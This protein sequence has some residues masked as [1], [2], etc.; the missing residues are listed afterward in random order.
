MKR[1]IGFALFIFL[2]VVSNQVAGQKRSIATELNGF[3]KKYPR[4]KVALFISQTK[5]TPGDT[6]W[7]HA[8][9]FEPS[10]TPFTQR[11]I[12]NLELVD[13][14]GRIVHRQNA[15][16]ADGSA[17]SYLS[18]PAA[19]QEGF[20]LIRAFTNLMRNF[21]EE[22]F[23]WQTIEVVRERSLQRLLPAS[24]IS[25]HPEGGHLTGG[26]MNHLV[27]L[28]H[29]LP[30]GSPV[31]IIGSV[32]GVLSTLYVVPSGI[33]SVMINPRPGETIHAVYSADITIKSVE[34]KAEVGGIALFLREGPGNIRLSFPAKNYSAKDLQV[35]LLGRGEAREFLLRR[36]YSDSLIYDL[37]MNVS[38]GYYQIL[39]FSQDKKIIANR[40][41]SKTEG[42]PSVS[43]RLQSD[44]A[45]LRSKMDWGLEL[46][47]E[48]GRPLNGIFQ[49][50]ITDERAYRHFTATDPVSLLQRYQGNDPVEQTGQGSAGLEEIAIQENW[51]PAGWNDPAYRPEH[52]SQS[53]LRL[54][55]RVSRTDG[56]PFRD[57][58]SVMLFLQKK[59]MGYEAEIHN[60][61]FDAPVYF[62]FTGADKLFF[63][64]HRNDSAINEV[65]LR[66]NRDSV[67]SHRAPVS[68][69]VLS[70]D[71]FADLMTRKKT[72]DRSYR[73]FKTTTTFSTVEQPDPNRPFE[74][75]LQGADVS[76]QIDD[77]VVFPTLDDVIREIVPSLKHRRL[78]GRSSVRVF[79]F[80]PVVLNTPILSTDDPL[81]IIDGQMTKSTEYFMN[82]NPADLISIRIVRNVQKLARFG[83]LGKNGVVLVKTRNPSAILQYK[84][85]LVSEINGLNVVAK[86]ADQ[87]GTDPRIPDLRIVLDWK[88]AQKTDD[89]G[90]YSSSFT[91]GD[92]TG[93]FLIRIEGMTEDGNPFFAERKFDVKEK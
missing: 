93:T 52:Q 88:S 57:S 37:P 78:N 73:F 27:V 71:P 23:S 9:V 67:S 74:E 86:S 16:M 22:S 82:M 8:Q 47:D 17:N 92:L 3:L 6:I 60:A 38:S 34:R 31:K 13:Q 56:L 41:W 69:P 24:E 29:G 20:Y 43:L 39:V 65:M 66:L 12:L 85:N 35:I 7:F 32:S 87:P 59:M 18:I 76:V 30:L 48:N 91:T 75:T 42:Q 70:R 10:G 45:G 21:G 25:L 51:L 40:I 64:V 81:Y 26:V 2:I 15:L 54:A 58:T 44:A 19:V 53:T 49:M 90:K 79:L 33:S 77:Y 84:E 11:Q 36:D 5:V 1:I 61:A 28:Y 68:K 14:N 55:G 83:Y 80:S 46:K 89:Q 63:A 4:T 50:T 72:T 62:D